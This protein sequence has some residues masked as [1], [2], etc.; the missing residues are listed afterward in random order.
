MT[1]LVS[2]KTESIRDLGVI[3]DSKLGLTQQFE[4]KIGRTN[5]A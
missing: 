5:R 4:E 2:E 1:K 3:V